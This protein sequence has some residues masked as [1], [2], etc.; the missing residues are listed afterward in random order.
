MITVE[1]YLDFENPTHWVEE[2]P[3]E[4][5]VKPPYWGNKTGTVKSELSENKRR[6]LRAKRKKK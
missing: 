4:V 6:E 2:S 5:V 1:K 3:K